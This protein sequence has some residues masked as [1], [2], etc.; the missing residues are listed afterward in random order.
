LV[1]TIVVIPRLLFFQEG[2]LIAGYG[3][4]WADWALHLRSSTAFAHQDTLSLDNPIFAGEAF[5]YPY[6]ANYLS[7]LLQRM[8]LDEARSLT[9]PT[10]LLF[11]SLPALLYNFGRQ[12]TGNR[13]AAV[14][15]TYLV[16]LAGGWGIV[17][18]LQDALAGRFFWH[19]PATAPLL[20][21]DLRGGLGQATGDRLGQ[22]TNAGIWFNNFVLSE[23]FPQRTFLAG[24]PVALYVLQRFWAD[25]IDVAATPQTPPSL[26]LHRLLLAG[27]LFGLLPLLHTHS[28]LA[29][30]LMTPML[31]LFALQRGLSTTR[32]PLP[33]LR[34]AIAFFLPAIA[35]GFPLL[36]WLVFDPADSSSFIHFLNGW[37]PQPDR[38]FNPVA[39]WWRNAG[40]IWV[41]GTLAAAWPGLESLRP[42]WWAGLLL[43]GL[44]NAVSFQPWHWDNL[45]LLTYWYLAWAILASAL[46]A[47]MPRRRWLVTAILL[48]VSL[49]AGAADVG[50]VA[51][52]SRQGIPFLSAAEVAFARQVE[53]LTR[54][55]PSGV[56]LAAPDHNHPLSMLSGLRLYVGYPGWLWSYGIDAS[57]RLQIASDIYRGRAI[58]SLTQANG[59]DYIALGSRERAYYQT[60]E[61]MLRSY[62]PEILTSGSESLLQ[63]GTCPANAGS[64]S[65]SQEF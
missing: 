52:A 16:L 50:S 59:I 27:S 7:S 20:Y 19:A 30:G 45:K 1:Y 22:P 61:A 10:L 62:F 60:D 12:L 18:L 34:A 13:V 8:G 25:S 51:I 15:L 56:L 14:V 42:W 63:V 3:N 36:F 2:D 21:T 38:P 58:P 17:Q 32:S 46:L 43:F 65:V 29:L 33:V 64:G 23:F 49:G 40:P 31:A 35:V 44:C 39:F 5:H 57:Q 54:N 47:R 53:I 55:C 6:L 9:W 48:I 26:M 41:L 11:G 4:V 28:F 37:V 24:L